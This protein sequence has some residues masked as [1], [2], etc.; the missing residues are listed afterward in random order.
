MAQINPKHGIGTQVTH[1]GEMRNPKH[2]HVMPIFQT[3]AFIFPDVASAPAQMG[4]ADGYYYTRISN[5]NSEHLAEKYAVLEAIDLLRAHPDKPLNE[6][7][8]GRIFASG[9]AAI[10]GAIVSRAQAGDAIIAQSALYGNTY[11]FIEEI[12]PRVGMHVVWVDEPTP[13]KWE[14]AFARCPQAK[15]A[16]V[17][18]PVNPTMEIVDLKSVIEIA[19]GYGSWVM[20]DNTF[21]TPYCQRPLTLGADVVIHSTTKYLTGHGTVIGGA[22][23]SPHLD[24][25]HKDIQ[26]T[27]KLYGGASSPFDAWLANLG[28]KTFELRMQ[29]HCQNAMRVAEYLENHPKVAQVNY[30]GLESFPGHELAAK[31]MSCYG[32]MLSFELADGFTAGETLMNSLEMITLAVSLGNV[33]SLIQHPASMT[34]HSVPREQRLAAGITDGLVRF[35]VGIEEVED[36]LEDLEYGLSKI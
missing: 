8:A 9:M 4:E 26:R 5:P 34:H 15:L 30:P 21:S 13:E 18:T 24:Y 36:L 33:D 29:R 28:L 22:V 10:S 11:N 27:M 20:V 16:F 6:V 25:M 17:E 3:S 7:A 2:A 1:V 14:A 31:Q 19:H 12:A 32:G 35:S 23:I